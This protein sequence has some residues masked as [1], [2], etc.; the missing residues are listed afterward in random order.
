MKFLSKIKK[1]RGDEDDDDLDLEDQPGPEDTG[2]EEDP[3]GG[4]LF[5]KLFGRQKEGAEDTDDLDGDED[6]TTGLDE[7]PPVQRV[8]LEGIA[9]VRPVG[10]AAD[11]MTPPGD[12]AGSGAAPD[13]ATEAV[14]LG[15][16]QSVESK[17]A[18]A[19]GTETQAAPD[20]S[21][22]EQ[23]P[24]PEEDSAVNPDGGHRFFL[25]GY[26]RRSRR[27]RRGLERLGRFPG[28]H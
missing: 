20:D 15:I 11:T 22:Q 16:G 9:D 13:T 6:D 28:R 2:D 25:E 14:A 21:S 4:G 23:V 24:E 10:P 7:E 17:S 19:A 18:A 12:P 8:R 27:S 5:R 3:S 1:G 26:F